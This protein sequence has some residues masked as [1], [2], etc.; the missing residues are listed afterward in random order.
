MPTPS[1]LPTPDARRTANRLLDVLQRE[2]I[3][4]SATAPE[5]SVLGPCGL[6]AKAALIERAKGALTQLR[7]WDLGPGQLRTAQRRCDPAH[8]TPRSS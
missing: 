7:D 8:Q 5:S 4:D 2:R 1:L 3:A 6:D